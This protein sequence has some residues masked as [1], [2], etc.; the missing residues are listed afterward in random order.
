MAVELPQRTGYRNLNHPTGHSP[1]FQTGHPIIPVMNSYEHVSNLHHL[2]RP[3]LRQPVKTLA[4]SYFCVAR[5]GNFDLAIVSKSEAEK[6]LNERLIAC[7][8]ALRFEVYVAA[9]FYSFLTDFALRRD[10][11]SW[12]AKS[13]VLHVVNHGMRKIEGMFLAL[14]GSAT[15]R[16]HLDFAA[17]EGY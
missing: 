9:S 8:L 13:G 15:F 10:G 6:C 16:W 11:W 12:R 5:L 7:T 2:R 17:W 1:R 3:A 4:A 14:P